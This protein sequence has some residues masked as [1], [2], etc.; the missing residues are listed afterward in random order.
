MVLRLLLLPAFVTARAIGYYGDWNVY[1]NRPLSSINGSALTHLVYSFWLPQPPQ[2]DMSILAS[3]GLNFNRD[4][5]I[6]VGALVPLD[7]WAWSLHKPVLQS[8]RTT[9]PHVKQIVAVGGWTLSFGMSDMCASD[10]SRQ[11]FVKSAQRLF[12]EKQFD[13][14]DID[15]E[16][17]GRAAAPTHRW[18]STDSQCL[19]KLVNELIKVARPLG[20]TVSV[21][22]AGSTLFTFDYKGLNA[23]WIGVMTYDM[24][25]SWT[26]QMNHQSSLSDTLAVA[27]AYVSVGFPPGK[28][29]L[30][31]PWYARGW[32]NCPAP[33]LAN[34]PIA[35]CGGGGARGSGVALTSDLSLA[36]VQIDRV[37]GGAIVYFPNTRELW[38]VETIETARLKVQASKK[39]GGMLIWDVGSGNRYVPLS[40]YAV[41]SN[42]VCK[43]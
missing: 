7:S 18:K 28:I 37:R 13:G 25:G 32:A 5:S 12:R 16:Y 6:P 11:Q 2:S 35:V 36:N 22:V 1:S 21:A 33:Q 41:N 40:T 30:G 31:S 23:D 39:Y 34:T 19:V 24:A 4:A 38:S 14:I 9:Y 15:W 17:P 3:L 26:L 29:V 27:K 10:T 8:W 20:A 43:C 42:C